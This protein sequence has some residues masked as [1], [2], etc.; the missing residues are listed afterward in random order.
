M[1]LMTQASNE[2][3]EALRTRPKVPIVRF[4]LRREDGELTSTALNHV[5][6][7]Q[8]DDSMLLVKARSQY[9]T[10]LDEDE[11]ITIRYGLPVTV[12]SDYAIYGESKLYA[13]LL[14]LLEEGKNRESFLFD[15]AGYT[16]GE[17]ILTPKGKKALDNCK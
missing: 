2:I 7:L 9:I 17:I 5:Y 1:D 13:D 4:E 15:K 12:K 14:Q 16:K 3:I 11:L 6:I 8:K 10:Q